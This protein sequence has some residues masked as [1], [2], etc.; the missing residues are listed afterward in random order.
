MAPMSWHTEDLARRAGLCSNALRG[1]QSTII[2][3]IM[4]CA[5]VVPLIPPRRRTDFTLMVRGYVG[6]ARDSLMLVFAILLKYS[7]VPVT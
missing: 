1:C 3:F 6:T 4:S 7:D 2:T 5:R